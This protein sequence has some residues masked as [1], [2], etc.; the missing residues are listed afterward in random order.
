[1]RDALLQVRRVAVN[2]DMYR[3]VTAS[4]MAK[5][6]APFDAGTI[7]ALFS[8]ECAESTCTEAIT[9]TLA[10]YEAVRADPEQFVI[11]TATDH[12]LGQLERVVEAN[13]RYAVV[14]RVSAE[15][16]SL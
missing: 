8:C 4:W 1:M 9:M 7:T 10:E 5:P 12:V 13:D 15:G 11:A 6:R 2:L 16:R 3:V 14:A